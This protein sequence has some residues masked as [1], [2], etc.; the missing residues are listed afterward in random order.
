MGK[1]TSSAG[2]L[3]YRVRGTHVEVLLGHMGGPYWQ[4][5]DAGAWT[6]PK[7]EHTPD[8][9]PH[10]AALREFTEE[11]GQRPPPGPDIDLGTVRQRG[12]KTVAAWAR[13]ADLDV[14][15]ITSNTF[16]IEWPP[17]SG[18][19]QQFPELDRAAWLSLDEAA[20]AVVS[21]QAELIDRLRTAV[22][23]P[24]P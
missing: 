9:D 4:A 16:E 15:T 6:I 12:G 19:R 2:L 21:G 23:G 1:A 20:L 13:R 22:A 11:I 8:E 18:R 7:G 14:S 5:K 10:T 3:L 17:R 24:V